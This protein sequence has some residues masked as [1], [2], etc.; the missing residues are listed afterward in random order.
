MFAND[1][2][3]V[4]TTPS[5]TRQVYERLRHDL[6]AGRWA[7]SGKLPMHQLRDCY[8]SGA[9]PLREAL[10][11]LATEGLVV[12]NEQRGFAAA[13]VSQAELD[14]IVRTRMGVE[15]MALA[16]AFEHRTQEGE[17]AL[18]LA[19]HRLSRTP[20]S[21]SADSYE[22]N[23]QW[24]Q[25]HRAFHLALLAPCA[26]PLLLGFC[27]QLY[28]RAYRYRQLAARKAYKQRNEHDEHRAIFDAVLERRLD[29][30]RQL[31]AAH[32]ERTAGLF[33]P[34]AES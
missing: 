8:E 29:D 21:V 27:E 13:A 1:A 34:P 3:S 18:V 6:L 22:E 7:P 11:R 5:L 23:P 20:R 14:D 32:Y 12:H 15:A 33:T 31:M 28:D 9:S 16:Q 10:S 19:Y 26:S 4:E 2:S 30:A 17:E 25:Y 24:E